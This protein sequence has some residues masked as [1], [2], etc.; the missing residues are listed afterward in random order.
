MCIHYAHAFIWSHMQ[1]HAYCGRSS[2]NLSTYT[3][4]CIRD[5]S[6]NAYNGMETMPYTTGN[7]MADKEMWFSLEGWLKQ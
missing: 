3:V 1:V 7:K 5:Y 2:V 6:I 4:I